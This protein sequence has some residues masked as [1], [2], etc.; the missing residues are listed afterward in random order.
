M[1]KSVLKNLGFKTAEKTTLNFYDHWKA[2]D[3]PEQV[4]GVFE[5]L[6]KSVGIPLVPLNAEEE[7]WVGNF[8]LTLH[9]KLTENSEKHSGLIPRANRKLLHTVNEGCD[10]LQISQLKLE[11]IIR[12]QSLARGYLA[13]KQLKEWINED[14]VKFTK[15]K[16][17]NTNTAFRDLLEAESAYI[18]D[19]EIVV[20]KFLI[21][22]RKL[23]EIRRTSISDVSSLLSGLSMQSAVTLTKDDVDSIFSNVETLLV[24]HKKIHK[25]LLALREKFPFIHNYGGVFL[26]IVPDLIV[27]GDF[28]MNSKAS[29]DSI[30][31]LQDSEPKFKSFLEENSENGNDFLVY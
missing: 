18:K 5:C 16:R 2:E 24:V 13:R 4:I 14:G 30:V 8:M 25:K 27:Y 21:P 12:V 31:R 28:V 22:L 3:Y 9:T 15:T 11:K 1:G 17:H 26:N 29:L 7:D 20:N 23:S 10:A 6:M 19:L